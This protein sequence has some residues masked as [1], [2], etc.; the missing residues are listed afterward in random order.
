LKIESINLIQKKDIAEA[1]N[2]LDK[3]LEPIN[4]FMGSVSTALRGRLS[5]TDNFYC[6][7]KEFQFTHAV[8]QQISFSLKSYSGVMVIKVPDSTDVNKRLNGYPIVRTIDN[9]T[10]GV[11][12]YFVGAGTTTGTIKFLILG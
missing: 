6:E 12:F 10:I 11:T 7:T 9:Q 3:L 5:F 8:E 4:L 1:P 2:W